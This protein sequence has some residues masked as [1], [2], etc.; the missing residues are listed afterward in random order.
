[1]G[2]TVS[3]AFNKIEAALFDAVVTSNGGVSSNTLWAHYGS[4]VVSLDD[5]VAKGG[6][7][8]ES[9]M[10]RKRRVRSGT[11]EHWLIEEEEKKLESWPN[12]RS[13]MS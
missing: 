11:F 5:C 6:S 12:K 1:M 3:Q 7:G 4:P 13:N 10:Q 9:G 2:D 8:S